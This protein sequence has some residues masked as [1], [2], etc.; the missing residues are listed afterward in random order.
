MGE[1]F[2]GLLNSIKANME[3]H[4]CKGSAEA[5]F[6]GVSQQDPARQRAV[7]NLE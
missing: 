3:A 6:F 1:G 4:L 2:A 5:V 7:V